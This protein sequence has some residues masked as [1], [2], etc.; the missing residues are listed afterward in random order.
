MIRLNEQELK[1]LIQGGETNIVELKAAAPRPVEMAER[2]CG[3]VNAQGGVIII[4]VEDAKHKIIGVPDD[5]L[6]MTIDTV[7]RAARQN[8][9]PALV[10]EPPEPE[11]YEVD[12]KRLVVAAVPPSRGPVYQSGGVFWVRRGTHTVPLDASELLELMGDRGL[13]EWERHAARGSTMEDIDMEKVE[14]HLARRSLR[15]RQPGRFEDLER[16]LVGMGCAVVSSG[17]DVIPTNASL[18]FFGRNPQQYIIQA[19]V[20]C[21][22]FR[23]TVGASRYADRRIVTGTLQELIDGAEAFL[24]RYIAVGARVEGWKRID[25]PEYSIEV[26]REAVIN[27]VVHRDYNK[28][29]E[30]IRVFYYPDRVEVHS[31]GLL[32]PGITVE[33][34]ERG[35]VQSKLRNPIL[36]GLL[37]DIPGY[38]ERIGSGIRFMLDETKRV[39]LPAPRFRETGEFIVTFHKAPELMS[40]QVRPQSQE[41]LWGDDGLIQP[42]APEPDIPDER[43][44]RLRKAIEYVHEHGS[45]TNKVY[46]E[47]TGISDRTA[48]RDLELLLERGRLRGVG[49]RAARRYVLA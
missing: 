36:A 13:L 24:D 6:A 20:V 15:D 39:G 25:I 27:A 12:G 34:M 42:K 38:M 31:P 26:L 49:Q 10:L 16:T 2:L 19:E 32:L 28:R 40:P 21:V 41:T 22:L 5:R 14:T 1:R 9:K 37:R 46:R 8:V 23:E 30:S 43:E 47:L 35:E 18:L 45:I 17:G 29:G 4:G 7:L 48:H 3:M 11:T 33:Q 44:E